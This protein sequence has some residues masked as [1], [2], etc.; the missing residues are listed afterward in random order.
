MLVF[1][2]DLHYQT[3][4]ATQALPVTKLPKSR[5]RAPKS[6]V[7]STSVKPSPWILDRWRDLVLFVAT[8][9]LLIPIFTA[10]QARWS[11]QDIFLFVGAFGAM[12]HHL[13]GMIRAYGD[14]ALFD[15]FKVRFVVAP[16]LI[17]GVC[18][19][20]SLYN[21]QA[22]Q[23]VA[24]AWGIWHG[25]MQT[26]GFCRIYDAKASAKAA[27]RARVDLALCFA[28]FTGAVLLSP[29]RF[30]S[31][32]D[33]YYE[34]G[35]PVIPATL[36]VGL[37]STMLAALA[38]AT[39]VFLW[40][41]WVDWRVGRGASP[42]KMV[43]LVSSI[44][45]WWY[46]NNGVQNILVGIALFEVFHDVQYL[47]IVWIYNRSRVERDE[48]IRGFMR[49]VFRRSGSLIGVYVGLVLAYG[50]IA[51]TTSGVSAE[52]I[53][54]GLI[55]VV[56]ASALLHF[57]YD[58]FIWKVRETQTRAMLGIEGAGAGAAAVVPRFWPIWV[59]HGLR[60]AALVIPFGALCAAQLVGRIV[61]PIE[62]TAKVAEVLPQD[63]QAQLNYGKALHAAGRTDEAMRKYEFAISRNPSLAEAEFFLG[64]AWSD[65]GDLDRAAEHYKRSL[66]LD[67]KNGKWESNL[68]GVLVAKGMPDEARRHYE[69]SLALAPDLQIAHKELADLLC[70]SGEYDGA[71]AHYEEAL[72]IQPDYRAAKE[73]LSFARTLA[74]R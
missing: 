67:P 56:T 13:P 30:R 8:P 46:C 66:Q 51:L 14:R 64:L 70:A 63:P 32:F 1:A 65:L 52:W 50:S 58:G 57:Y 43:L 44:A 72:R 60:W 37:R 73:N 15:R 22:I 35:G 31:A 45:F 19:W 20:S 9:V 36:I 47:A 7:S 41:Q 4:M 23:L 61:P 6:E 42:V 3:I 17:L 10:A 29:M 71:I 16:L 26:Y 59:R 74:G 2:F 38:L 25:M 39:A 18:I 54:H 5:P 11:A 69:R 12:G 53:R 68:A 48:S 24:L 34:S 21:I 49:F 27:S 55:G 40:R 33:L 28:W 62:R